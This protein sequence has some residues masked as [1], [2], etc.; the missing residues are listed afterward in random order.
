MSGT[1][2]AGAALHLLWVGSGGF[3]GAVGRYLV[4]GWVH[5]LLPASL[6]PWGTL[7]VNLLGCFLLGFLASHAEMRQVLG[8]DARLFLF[9][10]CLGGFTTFSTFGYETV[11]LVREAEL[12]AAL[13]NVV[14]HLGVGLSAVW[15]GY[16]AARAW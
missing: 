4:S 6:F 8:P 1:T 13:G 14:L 15:A 3:V 2:Q 11:A 10:G 9:I 7:T 12:L 16:A 5:R